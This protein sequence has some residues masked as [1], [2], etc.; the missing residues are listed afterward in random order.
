MYS[1]GM[2]LPVFFQVAGY[3]LSIQK[4][5][6]ALPVFCPNVLDAFSMSDKSTDADF[7]LTIQSKEPDM[8]K[9]IEHQFFLTSDKVILD[10]GTDSQ[11]LYLESDLKLEN[12]KLYT[13]YRDR[14]IDDWFDKTGNLFAWAMPRK[15]AVMLHGVLIEWQGKGIVLTAA[16]GTG[17]TTHARLWRE[18]E[19]ALIINGDRVLLRKEKEQWYAYGTPWSGSSGECVNRKVA[20]NAIVF[21][22]RGLINAVEQI[23]PL[24]ALGEMLPRTIAPKWHKEY[25]ELAV[26]YAVKCL[27]DTTLISLQCLPNVESV[28]VLKQ[29]LM[30]VL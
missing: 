1:L 27:E 26:D 17:K 13:S 20:L 24:Q 10:Y 23:S 18:H 21:L 22:H 16:S 14:S 28:S 4:E 9:D 30:T 19:N 29:K 2:F 15:G 11:R 7:T 25:S 5:R 8:K 12:W 6:G 3:H